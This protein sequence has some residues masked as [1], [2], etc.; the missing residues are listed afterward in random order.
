M[1]EIFET[2]SCTKCGAP[3][4]LQP[5]EMIITC[6]Y[7]GA[8][9]DTATG[10]K[11]FLK[12][13][14]IPNKYDENRI[15]DLTLRWMAAGSLKPP[16]LAAKSKIIETSCV[17]L[18]F[19]IVHVTVSS[20]Y[21]GLFTRT[22][23]RDPREGTLTKEYYWKVLGRRGSTFPVKEYEIPLSGKVNFDLAHLSKN[24]KFLNAEVGEKEA[25]TNTQQELIEHQRYLLEDDLDVIEE[26]STTFEIHNIEF[27]H[28][29]AWTVKY[30]FKGNQYELLID[31]ASGE[32]IR[33]DI[34]PPDTSMGGFFKEV[35]KALFG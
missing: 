34:P 35:K 19:F 28:A 13:S 31:G 17:F 15:R 4:K 6:E 1:T 29:P 12:H 27:V 25:E 9:T 32:V 20:K 5:G 18:P 16:T 33:G 30:V 26:F 14:L 22:G 8:T 11:Y 2:V 3:L 23:T 21:K 24:A 7:C 10:K